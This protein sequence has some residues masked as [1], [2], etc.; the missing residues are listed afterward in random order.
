MRFFESIWI[1][2]FWPLYFLQQENYDLTR[3]WSSFPRNLLPK[4]ARQKITATPK[5]V[6][7]LLLSF[8]LSSFFIFLILSFRFSNDLSLITGYFVNFGVDTWQQ[9]WGTQAFVLLISAVL[10]LV[11]FLF[12]QSIFYSFAVL[13]LS[14]IDQFLKN[15]IT[16][17]ASKKVKSWQKNELKN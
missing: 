11:L 6:S 17:K 9:F 15:Q 8:I 10:N 7:I 3:F 12:W 1:F 2:L 16:Q 4:K 14:P 13:I 5:L